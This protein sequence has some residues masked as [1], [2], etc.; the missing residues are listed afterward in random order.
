MFSNFHQLDLPNRTC[1]IPRS[2]HVFLG[3]DSS[4]IGVV[5]SYLTQKEL[6]LHPTIYVEAWAR[7]RLEIEP[8][9]FTYGH[10]KCVV[11]DSL[12]E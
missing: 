4:G 1:R 11:V 10:H 5:A 7:I 12:I 8:P 2:G 3:F 9:W 6:V